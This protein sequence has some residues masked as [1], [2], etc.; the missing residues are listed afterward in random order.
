SRGWSGHPFGPIERWP[1][2]LNV[3]LS[4]CL[5]TQGLSAVYWRPDDLLRRKKPA[6]SSAR[7]RYTAGSPCR[8]AR[9]PGSSSPYWLIAVQRVLIDFSLSTGASQRLSRTVMSSAQVQ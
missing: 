1:D 3:A 9:R 4:I 2:E 7:G 6:S 8:S 5:R